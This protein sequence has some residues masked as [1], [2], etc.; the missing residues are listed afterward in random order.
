[1][2]MVFPRGD[3]SLC[4]LRQ[5]EFR[6]YHLH[7]FH[8]QKALK[9]AVGK[10]KIFKRAST[11]TFLHRFA[12]HLLQSNCDIRTILELLGHSDVRTTMVYP[13]TIKEQIY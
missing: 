6:R 3:I 7:E 1:M 5:G 9:C 4:N 12:T 13:H 8:L 10:S 11:H 2:A